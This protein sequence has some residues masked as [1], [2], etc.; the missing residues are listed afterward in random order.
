MY[1][2]CM[3]TKAY[4]ITLPQKL[5]TRLDK[6][7]KDNYMTRSDFIRYAV[8]KELKIQEEDGWKTVVDFTKINKNGV[9]AE[10]VLKALKSMR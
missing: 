2:L 9:S 1:A 3:S 10:E 4:N 6:T 5:V 7:A 8:V